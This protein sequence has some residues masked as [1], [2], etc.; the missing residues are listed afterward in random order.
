MLSRGNAMR[1]ILEAL[2]KNRSVALLA[3][4][5]SQEATIRFFGKPCGT[6]LGPAVLHLRTGAPIVLSFSPRIG[7]GRYRMITDEPLDFTGQDPK[8]SPEEIM[9]R[10]HDRYEEVIR[11]Y[12]EQ[13]LWFHDRW[14]SARQ[15][16]LL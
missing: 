12:P 4:Q 8:P 2:K 11:Q 6:V 1:A 13:W 14:K 15:R 7:P 10:I 3:D 16:G 9:Q 5:N